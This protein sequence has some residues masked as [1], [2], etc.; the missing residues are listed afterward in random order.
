M[1]K[2]ST[3]GW[4]KPVKNMRMK[5]IEEKSLM[6]PYLR[7]YSL[8]GMRNKYHFVAG[9]LPSRVFELTVRMSTM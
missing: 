9:D 3:I 2:R 7:S 5:R 1:A 4:S 6:L 8:S